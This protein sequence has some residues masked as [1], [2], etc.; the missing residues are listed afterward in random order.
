MAPKISL[1]TGVVITSE[2]IDTVYYDRHYSVMDYELLNEGI[3]LLIYRYTLN[4]SEILYQDYNGNKISSIN[5]L[6]GKPLRLFK[7]CLGNVHIFT[8]NKSLEIQFTE[9]GLKLYPANSL[10][11][12]MEVMQY[13]QL[14]QNGRLYYHE[15]GYMALVNIYYSIDTLD[16]EKRP[17]YIVKDQEKLDFIAQNP[18]NLKLFNSN[19]LPSMNDLRGLPSDADILNHIRNMDEVLRFN[20]MAYFPAIYA[21]LFK[22]GDSLVIFNHANNSID[23][24]DRNDSL[25]HELPISYHLTDEDSKIINTLTGPFRNN[26]WQKEAFV[27]QKTGRLYTSFM[28]NS[29]T[30]IIREINQSSG[31]LTRSIKIPFP[32]VD[33]IQIFN[34]YIYY[35][36]KGW[37]E[38]QKMKLYTQQLK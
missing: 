12:F 3:I 2:K 28:N 27:D 23:F 8:R 10:D 26:K 20:Q 7:D 1:L 33:K 32:Y 34:G 24:F 36:Y 29:G 25:I 13:C 5:M 17:F 38:N 15:K 16:H 6:P 9:S 19:F 37:G 11:R 35:M 4:R 22:R 21:P 31:D 18:E 30:K 14:F